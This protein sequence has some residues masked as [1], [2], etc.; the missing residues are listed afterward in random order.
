MAIEDIVNESIANID[1]D[2]PLELN[3]DGVDK[4]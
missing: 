2:V 4:T 1:E 3:L